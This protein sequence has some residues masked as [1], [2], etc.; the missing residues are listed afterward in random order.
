MAD[1]PYR[2]APD[3]PGGSFGMLR[4]SRLALE[5]ALGLPYTTS[6]LSMTSADEDA[7]EIEIVVMDP[8]LPHVGAGEAIPMV[9][10]GLRLGPEEVC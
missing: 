2:L 4:I 9:S 8:H 7:A 6:I 5:R 3:A 10:P 1:S